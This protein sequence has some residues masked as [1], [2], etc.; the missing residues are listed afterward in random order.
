MTASGTRPWAKRFHDFPRLRPRFSWVDYLEDFHRRRPGVTEDVLA[1]STAI[2]TDPYRWLLEPL[3]LT[4]PVL[5]LACGSAPL[6][7][8]REW[9]GW[10]GVD[11]SPA[12]L[13]RAAEAGAT[14]LVRGDA[15]A[16]PFAT[17]TFNAVV[18]SMAI[19]LLE[20]LD[21]V[22]AEIR[23]VVRPG[24]TAV[25]MLPGSRP[26]TPADLLH[27][28]QLMTAVRQS[29]LAYPNDRRI[30]RLGRLLQ[31]AGFDLVA[32][33]RLRFVYPIEDEA[34]ARLFVDSLYLPAVSERRLAKA[35][36]AASRWMG[37]E[38]G[39]PLRRVVVFVT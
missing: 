13:A 26:L 16:L 6:L 15:A 23:R 5:D 4:G 37:Q 7:G 24:G 36:T 27:Y 38:I 2:G 8:A 17:G 34:S 31:K 35:S 19:M 3:R 22:L 1:R 21:S 10:V 12:E 9:E 39:I 32:D 30:A 29:H 28:G 25:F 11:R 33:E 14:P 20:P 18:C